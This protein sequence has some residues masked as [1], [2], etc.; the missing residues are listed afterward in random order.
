MKRTWT[1]IDWKVA[2]ARQAW[3]CA[4]CGVAIDA[5]AELD[6]VIA[7][8]DGGTNDASNAQLL[9]VSCHKNKSQ[10]EEQE[11]IARCRQA[12]QARA[13]KNL[14]PRQSDTLGKALENL[15]SE[16]HVFDF[17]F[18]VCPIIFTRRR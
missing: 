13:R 2:G 18:Y 12:I 11:R 17:S 4:S 8:S 5:T 15:L 6:H 16:E 7:L 14:Q 10:R 9:C 3:K 1:S